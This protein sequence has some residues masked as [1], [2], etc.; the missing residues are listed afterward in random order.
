[1][2]SGREPTGEENSA[3]GNKLTPRS[4]PGTRTRPRSGEEFVSF[5]GKP[6]YSIKSAR[7]T[8]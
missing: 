7:E 3:L 5:K 1:M 4:L 8:E 6:A 2:R